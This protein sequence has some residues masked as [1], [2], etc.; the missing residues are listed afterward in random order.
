MLTI[1]VRQSPKQNVLIDYRSKQ[2]I[3]CI[4]SMMYLT[5]EGFATYVTTVRTAF[6]VLAGLVADKGAFL[7][8]TL[9]ADITAKGTLASVCPMVFI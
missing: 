5:F 2:P 6:L 9:L 7:C 1:C 3:Y 8:E 4:I